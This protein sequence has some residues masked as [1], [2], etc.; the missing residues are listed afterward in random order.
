MPRSKGRG[1]LLLLLALGV[2]SVCDA[3][4]APVEMF[5]K[6]FAYPKVVLSPSGKYFA[7]LY[8]ANGTTN[9]AVV[10]V[11]TN[12]G[13][14][15]TAFSG[16]TEVTEV[17]WDTEDRLIYGFD[18]TGGTGIRTHNIAAVDRD[19]KNPLM[20]VDNVGAAVR[21]FESVQFVDWTLD[22]AKTVLLA[23]DLEN[24]NFPSVYEVQTAFA[25]HA[26]RA[27]STKSREQFSTPRVRVVAGPGRKCTFLADNAGSVRLCTT[28]EADGSSRILYRADGKSEWKKITA[29]ADST[30]LVSPIGFTPDNRT[31]YVLSN[32]DRDTIALF[33]M[34]PETGKLGKLVYEAPGVDISNPVW[35]SDR[36]TLLG[37]SYHTSHWNTHYFDPVVAQLQKDLQDAFAGYNI[38]IMNRSQ[39]AKKVI[40]LVNNDRT[41]GSYYLYDDVAKQVTSLAPLA[42][43]IDPKQLSP[44]QAVH[45]VARDGLQIDGYLTIPRGKEAKG[46]PLVVYPHGGPLAVRDTEDWN[47]DVQFLANR[48]YAVLQMNFRGSGGSGSKFREAGNRE[49]GGRMLDDITDGVMWAVEQ[50]VADPKRVCIFG[51]SYGG[52]AALMDAAVHPEM[53]RCAISY[54]GVTNLESVFDAQI[55][56]EGW[57]VPRSPEELAFLTRTLGD[58][59]DSDFL[60]EH[61][62]VYN[63]SK[64]AC[65]VFIA[66]GRQDFVVPVSQARQMREALKKANKTVEYLEKPDDGHGFH[67]EQNQI[68][69]FTRIDA[70]LKKYNPAD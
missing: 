22:D 53:F 10:D 67:N 2:A 25:W 61:S 41:P 64:I 23:S 51:A 37:V 34:D 68:E 63:A 1:R 56:G 40:V 3:A 44:V 19:G 13:H 49:W 21:R 15:L 58:R 65:P 42:P 50:G 30:R 57:T 4:G 47:P 46:L 32:R 9:L 8:P 69:L 20:L 39:D 70:F 27:P 55:V 38:T 18:A 11:A 12:A 48:G 62:P 24:E 26:M 36:R 66:H 6:S 28:L 17:G 45:Y 59:R 43:W 52:Y 29:F 14:P 7:A 31:L 60:R 35:S 54:S 5:Y 33:E 16:S